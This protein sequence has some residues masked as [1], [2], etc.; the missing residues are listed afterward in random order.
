MYQ[1]PVGP[2][3]IRTNCRLRITYYIQ[4]AMV[5]GGWGGAIRDSAADKARHHPHP[6]INPLITHVN[7]DRAALI[8]GSKGRKG[9]RLSAIS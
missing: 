7:N 6:L 9:H 8:S 4:S 1:I 2:L 5:P 3:M